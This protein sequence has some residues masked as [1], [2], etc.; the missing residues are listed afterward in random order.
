MKRKI[1][2][3][4]LA[5]V[6]MTINNAYAGKARS[7][8]SNTDSDYHVVH[9]EQH[10]NSTDLHGTGNYLKMRKEA[11]NSKVLGHLEQ[12]D[13]FVL[14]KL[15][16]GY[17]KVEIIESDKTS[18]D[19]WVGL[20][21]WVDADYINCYCSD[22]KYHSKN[23]RDF[24]SVSSDA[25]IPSDAVG[26]YIF[27]S[28]AGAWSTLITL[29]S[30]GSFIG[31]FGDSDMGDADEAYPNG[32]HYFRGFSGQ[33]TDLQKINDYTYSM[34]LDTLTP[35]EAK[36]HILGGVRYIASDPY[37]FESGRSFLMY[38]PDSPID[39]LTESFLSW[40]S[41]P[42]SVIPTNKL[43]CYAIYNQET[44]YAFFLIDN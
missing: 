21:G 8:V 11:K 34:T 20:T 30:D 13:H 3:L 44:G 36:D 9:L 42:L 18:P 31:D 16:N 6:L 23:P 28:G 39:A 2:V 19:S 4:F 33:F 27:C 24:T 43:G 1:F 17:A 12:A 14:L 32:T 41:G 38:T 10:L 37:G 29:S 5:L 7:I 40:I 35:W 22:A 26:E 15:Q 25:L